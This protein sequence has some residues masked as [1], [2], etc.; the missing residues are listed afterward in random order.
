MGVGEESQP[1]ATAY[2]GLKW[3]R[4]SNPNVQDSLSINDERLVRRRR[5]G[6][7]ISFS[8]HK[9]ACHRRTG[10]PYV[11]ID[12]LHISPSI[13]LSTARRTTRTR[14][15]DD[16]QTGGFA[17]YHPCP[18][19]IYAEDE[20]GRRGMLAGEA[21][22]GEGREASLGRC[23]GVCARR[24]GTVK[25]VGRA[26]NAGIDA[27]GDR[28]GYLWGAG[29]GI[30]FR[31]R[32]CD[33]T[34]LQRDGGPDGGG[35]GREYG[36]AWS[37][38]HTARAAHIPA[39]IRFCRGAQHDI[40]ELENARQSWRARAWSTTCGR[41]SVDSTVNVVRAGQ[42]SGG[43]AGDEDARRGLHEDARAGHDEERLKWTEVW[44]SDEV[45]NRDR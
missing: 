23:T 24:E 9:P 1:L 15:E 21:N 26:A 20:S 7:V 8:P 19:T 41:T 42:T 4:I 11:W 43:W 18:P 30:V 17:G 13:S 3:G 2:T 44:M 5:G 10:A 29:D 32:R 35:G 36:R 28:G 37:V 12:V 16:V 6:G 31:L 39:A 25:S 38:L 33:G 34:A 40:K 14:P 27:H 22:G 45:D